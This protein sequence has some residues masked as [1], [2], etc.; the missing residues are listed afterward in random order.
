MPISDNFSL[1]QPVNMKLDSPIYDGF[2]FG[3][4]FGIGTTI[5]LFFGAGIFL[6]IIYNK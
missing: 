5:S 1:L 4:G 2:N 3:L 6:K